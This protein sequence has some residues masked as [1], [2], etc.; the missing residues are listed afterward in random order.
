LEGVYIDVGENGLFSSD[1]FETVSALGQME[2][3]TPEEVAEYA[4]LELEARP[5]G[6]PTA[7]G[8]C[9]PTRW[10][11]CARWS[12]SSRPARSPTRCSV[13]HGSPNCCSSPTSAASCGPACGRSRN[14]TRETWLR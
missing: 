12:G 2:F 8:C 7:R 10:T 9:G 3:I 11:G 1:E 5:T 14:Q 13:P 6:R 4:V